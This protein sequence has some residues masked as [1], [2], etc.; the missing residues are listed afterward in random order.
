MLEELKLDTSVSIEAECQ[1]SLDRLNKTL[2]I[3]AGE[4]YFKIKVDEQQFVII[5]FKDNKEVKYVLGFCKNISE[6][7]RMLNIA[8]RIICYEKY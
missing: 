8:Y 3:V 7:I 2:N 6:C 5:R 4:G 1:H